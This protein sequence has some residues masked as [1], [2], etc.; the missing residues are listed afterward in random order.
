MKTRYTLLL[1]PAVFI[2]IALTAQGPLTP[3][4]GAPGPTM[5][6]LQQ[7]EPRVDVATLPGDATAVF[8]ITA[9]GSYFLSGNVTVPS[10]RAGIAIAAADVELDLGG[11]TVTGAAGSVR[12][13]ELR[14]NADNVRV[15]HGAIAGI[16]AGP[17]VGVAAAADPD[18][19]HLADLII[20]NC[21]GGIAML[22][23]NS[24]KAENISVTGSTS[25]GIDLGTRGTA[26]RCV[27]DATSGASAAA[28]IGIRGNSVIDC[29]VTGHTNTA[30]AATGISGGHVQGCTV[31]T[32]A[33]A[34][35]E[36]N[37]ILATDV[38]S[39]KVNSVI[40]TGVTGININVNGIQSS[41]HASHCTVSGVTGSGPA[42]RGIA[43]D[44]VTGCHVESIGS[45]ECTGATGISGGSGTVSQST[46]SNIGE[47]NMAAQSTGIVGGQVSQCRVSTMNGRA[48]LLGITAAS[49]AHCS[50]QSV[51]Q[52]GAATTGTVTGIA[53]QHIIECQVRDLN[54]ASP[55]N[56]VG[57]ASY[58]L[59]SHC[60]ASDVMNTGTG[61]SIGFQAGAG[62][63]TVDSFHS[64]GSQ[65]GM[66]CGN[67][68]VVRGC[69]ISLA[70]SGI[71]ISATGSQCVIDTN[72]IR[73]CATG[74]NLTGTN[75]LVIRNRITLC[76]VN[77]FTSATS[78]A[79]PVVTAQ[80]LIAST[81]PWANFT[82]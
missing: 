18:N 53:A 74:I 71:G 64:G 82:D 61:S 65:F 45:A 41:G 51:T 40:S 9:P 30:G 44:T 23:A 6:T 42:A 75:G 56:T 81:N 60:T 20:R 59:A 5:K 66:V 57:F 35:G 32:L 50:V 80:G 16:T 29:Q 43:A 8:L 78:Q 55:S 49:A 31:S 14:G 34:V 21:A 3:P 27:V 33:G 62:G 70:G 68:C 17:G 7:V 54:G 11:F 72:S 79:G 63:Q 37:G 19:V 36:T 67:G 24:V 73:S 47:F 22:Q 1:L 77:L 76:T 52:S 26:H 46:A 15:R 28:I 10:G 25:H 4:A 2:P 12:G 69:S 38:T 13:V 39:C 48:V 58:L